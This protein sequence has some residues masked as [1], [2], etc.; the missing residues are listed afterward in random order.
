MSK[1]KVFIA[2][3]LALGVSSSVTAQQPTPPPQPQAPNMSFFVTGAGPGKGADLGGI[4]GADRHCQ[5]LAERHGAGGKTWRAYLS[6]QP[7]DGKPAI[8]ARD[9]IGNGPWQNFKGTVVAANLDELH[10]DNNKLGFDNSLSERGQIIPGVG[11]APNRHDV[12]TGT[13]MEGRAFPAG[14]DRTCRNWTS[15]TQGAAM[16]GHIDKKGLRDDPPSKSWNSSHPSRGPDGG[17]SQADLRGTGGDGLFYCFAS[18]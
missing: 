4:E 14:D 6:T 2:T 12:L 13:T 3:A 17:C 8:N 10:S 1:A 9:R 18:N 16:V 11:F 5:T 15:S 7:A